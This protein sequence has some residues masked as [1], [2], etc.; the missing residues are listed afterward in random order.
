[1]A[2]KRSSSGLRISLVAAISCFWLCVPTIV[3]A[4]T[5]EP[6]HPDVFE[7]ARLVAPTIETEVWPTPEQL[8]SAGT[9][10]VGPT[11][12]PVSVDLRNVPTTPN[13]ELENVGRRVHIQ[14]NLD[15][16]EPRAHGPYDGSAPVR[17]GEPTL[18]MVDHIDGPLLDS[19]EASPGTWVSGF[20]ART[21]TNWFPPDTV[22]AVGPE[23]IVEAVNSGFMVYTKTGTLTRSYT[24]FS[25]F[26][27]LP[28]PWAGFCYDPR[29]VYSNEHG[30]FLMMIMGKDETNLKSYVWLMVSQTSDPNGNWWL[31]RLDLSSGGT[32]EEVWLDYASIGVDHWGVYVTGNYF[33]FPG[34]TGAGRTALW[35]FGP[36]IMDGSGSG[37]YVWGDVSWPSGGRAFTVQPALPHTQNSSGNS[38]LVATYPGSGSQICLFTQSGKRYPADPNPDSASL[39]GTAIDCKQYYAMYNNVDQPGSGWD[40]DGGDSRVMNAVYSQGKVYATLTLNWDG[41]RVYSEAYIAALDVGGTLAWDRPIWNSSLNFFYPAITVEGTSSTPDVFLALSLTEP[42]SPTGFASAASV[43]AVDGGASTVYT[44]NLGNAAYSKWDGDFEGD[45]RNRWG[46]YSGAG[47]DW[48]CNAA[49][50]AAEHAVAGND[51]D[52]QIT[53]R[54]LGTHDPCQYF[55]VSSP[56][57]GETLY[58]GNTFSINWERMNIPS[59]DDIKVVLWDGA[60]WIHLSGSLASSATSYSWDIPNTPAAGARIFVGSNTSGSST[61]NASDQSDATFTIVGRPD[62]TYATFLPPATADTGDTF[63]VLNRVRNDGVVTSGA[64]NVDLRL[65]TNTICSTTDFLLARWSSGGLS[66]GALVGDVTS[67]SIPPGTAGG[68]QYLCMLVD[69]SGIVAEFDETNNS[70]YQAIAIAH[71]TLFWDDFES[72]GVSAWTTSAP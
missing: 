33:S 21:D 19:P 18:M 16:H 25:G 27:N 40:I 53:A 69:S 47:W 48:T 50:G 30:K 61:W 70:V 26:V 12:V 8:V 41:N 55:H 66:P 51:W 65:S 42:G 23:Y 52:T 35:S 59:G 17:D 32:G 9:T 3:G 14:G 46:D 60:G 44:E 13:P 68:T 64:F 45:G 11:G 1:M 31:Y 5:P 28:S 2:S 56:N 39:S 15:A 54:T 62:L 29:V 7:A 72:G 67:V 71:T 22:M 57:G 6:P 34:S 43:V 58:A 20:D 37:S 10:K 24:S 38:F 49:W 36:G 63:D 4:Q